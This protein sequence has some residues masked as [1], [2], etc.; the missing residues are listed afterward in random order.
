MA[1]TIKDLAKETGLGYATISAF[2]NGNNVRPANKEK[3]EKA[4]AKLGYIRNDFARAL[5]AHSSKTIGVL[6]PELASSFATS[7]ISYMEDELRKY[8]YGIIVCD[9]RSDKEIEKQ[10]LRFMISKMVDGLII[11]PTSEDKNLLDIVKANNIPVVVIDRKTNADGVSHI[12][13]NNREISEKAVNNMLDMGRRQIALIYGGDG[14]YTSRERH[15]GYKEALDKYGLYNQ[16][17]IR[18]GTLSMQGGYKAM[19]D[20]ITK[21]PEIDGVF[22]TNF[23][24]TLGALLAVKDCGKKLPDDFSF[25]GFDLGDMGK[26]I[27]QTI[28]AVEQ[29]LSDIG[30]KAGNTIVEMIKTK[31]AQD[32][33]L[34]ATITDLV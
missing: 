22:V 23:E 24:M 15:V 10:S 19:C 32:I 3:I 1:I 31:L 4:I 14:V 5:K 17:Y 33:I 9:C 21:Y 29:P 12:I 30:R 6:I 18:N 8:G 26:L 2:L 27:S 34:K 11:M 7:I 28:Q 16:K 13:I 20:L 25:T